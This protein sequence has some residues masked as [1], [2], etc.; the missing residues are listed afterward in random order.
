MKNYV[1]EGKVLTL[2]AP[3]NRLSGEGAKVGSIF[4]VATKDVLNGIA[5]EFATQGVFALK[6]AAS[7]AWTVG[8]KIFWDD[9][10]KQLTSVAG[11]NL[12]VG[13][14]TEA[15]AGGAGDVV[16]KIKLTPL[17]E[18]EASNMSQGA[19]VADLNQD[20]SAAYV[21]AEVQAISDKVDELLASLRAAGV[22][23][24]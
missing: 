22:I 5:G 13:Y 10:A 24:T 2:L 19:A 9:S 6:K 17:G 15:V 12:L 11:A 4:G 23:A 20:I 8:L 14:A 7:Q 3:Y 16:G 18:S 21:E 1:Q